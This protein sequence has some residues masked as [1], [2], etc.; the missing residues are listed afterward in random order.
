MMHIVQF[1][2][3]RGSWQINLIN[4]HFSFKSFN[5]TKFHKMIFKIL[6]LWFVCL[7]FLIKLVYSILLNK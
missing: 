5:K 1:E 7:N 3:A 4:V 6:L 2:R